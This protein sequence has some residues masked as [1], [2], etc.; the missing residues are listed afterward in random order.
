MIIIDV[1][2]KP[3]VTHT[4]CFYNKKELGLS[5]QDW[6]R[7]AKHRGPPENF[8]CLD[9]LVVFLLSICKLVEGEIIKKILIIILARLV[10]PLGAFQ[11]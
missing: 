10:T 1:S 11:D 8:S 9:S 7:S 2:S 5:T 3:K 6:S 4:A